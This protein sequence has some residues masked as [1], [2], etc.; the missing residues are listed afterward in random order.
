VPNDVELDLDSA[1]GYRRDPVVQEAFEQ[2]ASRLREV[3]GWMGPEGERTLVADLALEGGG[4][5][6][7]GLV[8]AVTVLSEAGYSFRCVAGTSAGAIAATLITAITKSG[9]AMQDLRRYLGSLDFNRFVLEGR[10]H[11]IL[12]HV[13]GR[14]GSLAVDAAVLSH[15]M[16][17]YSGDYLGEWLSPI[18]HDELG[19]RTFGDLKLT[20]E[21][22]P[23]MSVPAGHDY[24]LLVHTSDITRGQLVHLPWDYP[25]YGSEPDQQDVVTAV[26]ASMSIPFFFEPVT[27]SAQSAD[28]SMPGP[29]GRPITQHY[30]A[31]TVTWV[32]GGMLRNFPIDAFDRAD[33]APP[34]WPT[35]GIKLSSL[36]TT[37][38]ATQ[39]CTS[40]LAVGLRCLHTLLN[41]WDAYAV[42][43]ATAARTIFVDNGGLTATEFGLTQDQQ[44]ML[45]LNGVR[46]ATSYVVEMSE[47]GRVPRTAT[48]GFALARARGPQFRQETESAAN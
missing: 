31:G 17:L 32:D 38:S 2:A 46:A 15:K 21:D 33:G 18:L 35:I 30:E 5:K 48:E 11:R 44:D 26:R 13:G 27:F 37:F 7:I 36:Q 29:G 4:V 20:V 25:L 14:A 8:G 12:D 22:D 10:V 28:V 34:R 3:D 19:V 41:E 40:S 1:C 6:G 39:G 24:R 43:E 16:G 23:G 9:G 45:F 47:A 42:D